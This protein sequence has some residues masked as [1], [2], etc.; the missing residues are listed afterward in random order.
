V[1]LHKDP[2]YATMLNSF[3]QN[4]LNSFTEW[5]YC[6]PTWNFSSIW[7]LLLFR[8]TAHST[9]HSFKCGIMPCL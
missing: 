6:T 8:S 1:A 2:A 3:A 7:R 9:L 5:C 4:V